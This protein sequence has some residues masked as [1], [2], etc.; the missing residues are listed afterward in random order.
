[1]TNDR[2]AYASHPLVSTQK[3]NTTHLTVLFPVAGPQ[4]ARYPRRAGNKWKT[5]SC[6][7]KLQIFQCGF[8]KRSACVIHWILV[9]Q[10]FFTFA[11][12][13]KRFSTWRKNNEL[14]ALCSSSETSSYPL[15]LPHPLE[16][17][18]ISQ[19]LQGR[20]PHASRS[21]AL[22]CIRA[23]TGSRYGAGLT[24]HNCNLPKL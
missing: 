1:M 22:F 6:L 16:L 2:N 10:R 20:T 13:S 5:F 19:P 14:V 17:S 9:N 4:G 21:G 15:P 12:S 8:R 24:C 23:S 18:S 7:A 3:F 11:A